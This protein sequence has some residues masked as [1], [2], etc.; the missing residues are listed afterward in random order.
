MQPRGALHTDGEPKHYVQTQL[1]VSR[2]GQIV[3]LDDV[4][5]LLEPL[6]ELRDLW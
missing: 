5:N 3:Q 1:D 6:L 4:R 2:D